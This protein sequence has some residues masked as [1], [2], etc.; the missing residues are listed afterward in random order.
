MEMKIKTEKDCE[1]CHTTH[2]VAI[3]RKEVADLEFIPVVKACSL[4]LCLVRYVVYS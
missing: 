3:K 1:Y 4:V 2:L